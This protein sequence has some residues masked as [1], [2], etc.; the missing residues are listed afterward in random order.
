MNASGILLSIVMVASVAASSWTWIPR[1]PTTVPVGVI[2]DGRALPACSLADFEARVAEQTRANAARPLTVVLGTERFDVPVKKLGLRFNVPAVRRELESLLASR[3]GFWERLALRRAA[4]DGR[5][6]LFTPF[7][8][9]RSAMEAFFT[10]LKQTVDRPSVPARLDLLKK[11][12]VPSVNGRLLDVA[13]S[14]AAAERAILAGR[15]EVRLAVETLVP[16]QTTED[17]AAL[18]LSTVLGW[19]ETSFVDHGKFAYRAHNLKMGAS[20]VTGIVLLPNRDFSFNLVVGPRT[21]KEGYRMA[22]VISLGELVDD[23][24]GGMCQIAS[25]IFAAAF[26]AGLDIIDFKVHTQVSHYIDLGLDAT[27]VYPGVD[28][29][30]RNP[31]PFPIAIRMDVSRGRVRAEILGREKPYARIGFERKIVGEV[32]FTTTM[33]PDDQMTRGTY[34]LDQRGQKGYHVRRRR[35]FFDAQG[36][37]VKSETWSL[38]YPP[39]AMIIREGTKPPAD[40]TAPLPPPPEPYKP[41]GDPTEFRREIQ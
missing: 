26:F 31:Y 7:S 33:R 2:V 24:G 25:T 27:V 4:R 18:S 12:V 32:P 8:Y 16:N 34:K 23:I 14:I 19:Y 30:L 39:A 1:T 21:T 29:I 37:E 36:V 6:L 3:T 35:I 10:Q 40:P 9:D 5:V 28:L 13:A 11:Q 38:Y 15:D 20:K 17:L 22:P 41:A